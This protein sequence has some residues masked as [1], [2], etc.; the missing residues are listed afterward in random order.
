MIQK[1]LRYLLAVSL[2]SWMANATLRAE[3]I[4]F[5][6]ENPVFTFEVPKECKAE[7]DKP[8]RVTF[9]AKNGLFYLI[10]FGQHDKDAVKKSLEALSSVPC[11]GKGATT[12]K[13]VAAFEGKQVGGLLVISGG[14]S[15]EFGSGGSLSFL[16][17]AFSLDGKRFFSLGFYDLNDSGVVDDLLKSIKPVK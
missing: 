9:V 8:D 7:L 2:I 5:P 10:E 11:E 4:S 3:T 1:R 15:G 6:K 16:Q 13:K 12:T 14:C 17:T